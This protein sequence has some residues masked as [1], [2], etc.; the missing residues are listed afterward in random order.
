MMGYPQDG[1]IV[2]AMVEPE[3]RRGG[4]FWHQRWKDRADIPLPTLIAGANSWES[5]TSVQTWLCEVPLK[6]PSG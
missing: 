6:Q 1:Q 2:E 4:V 5:G 3:T